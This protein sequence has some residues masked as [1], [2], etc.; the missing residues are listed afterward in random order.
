MATIRKRS[1]GRYQV[2]VRRQGF[3]S[4]TRTFLQLKDAQAWA[5]QMEIAADRQDLPDPKALKRVTLGE[6]VTR[7][8]DQVTCRKRGARDETFHLSAFLRHELCRKSLAALTGAMFSQY[9]D[10][11]L[12]SV[13]PATVKRLLAVVHSSRSLFSL[14]RG[15]SM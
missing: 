11:R 13:K 9:R 8:R 10:E 14:V 7:Y 6:L 1:E 2:Q 4:Q 12:Q 5:R 3:P 15:R